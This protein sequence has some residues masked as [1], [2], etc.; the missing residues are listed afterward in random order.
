MKLAVQ[1]NHLVQKFGE[2]VWKNLEKK[3]KKYFLIFDIFFNL[4]NS[5]FFRQKIPDQLN[6]TKITTKKF[7]HKNDRRRFL[8]GS[9]LQVP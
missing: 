5:K 3:A 4:R 6:S 1:K 8:E 9:K 7:F 2:K